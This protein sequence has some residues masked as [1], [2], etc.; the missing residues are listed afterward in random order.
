[1]GM[2]DQVAQSQSSKTLV[3]HIGDHKT[4][5]TTLQN[6]FA[7]GA[8]RPQT[9][10][11]LYPA[12]LN[13]NYLMGFI[14]SHL[15][16]TPL[17]AHLRKKPGLE[18][19]ASEIAD[20]TADYIVLSGE[21]FENIPAAGFRTVVDH[22][23]R[24]HVSRIHII[25]Y[26][27]PHAERILSSFGEQI[28]IGWFNQTMQAFYDKNLASRRFHYAPRFEKWRAAF[29]PDF[30]LRPMVRSQLRGGSV[31]ED[32]AHVA[33]D[34]QPCEFIELES[35]NEALG[36]RE[37]MFL[38][39]VQATF[40]ETGQWLRHTLGWEMARRI[41]QI[42]MLREAPQEKLR[43]DTALW[44]QIQKSYRKDAAALDKMFFEDAPILQDALDAMQA[45]TIETPQSVD[46]KDYF[47]PEEQRNLDV[48]AAMMMDMLNVQHKW[49]AYFHRHRLQD[50]HRRKT[51]ITDRPQ[52]D[53][54]KKDTL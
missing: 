46:P 50:V 45:R 47:T 43:M 26:V 10:E 54:P 36:L 22:F 23:F 44:A 2:T 37:L 12:K 17:P 40:N 49:P 32:F 8:V 31:I 33:F 4:G 24:P 52:A 21:V 27:R 13:H 14:K 15:E 16:K 38:K 11:L 30:T 25:A 42:P 1:M 5:T 48:M 35:E 3:I 29:G 9:V 28:K 39:H 7:V 51:A 19:L 18:E 6:A 20:S 34:G 53:G 41:G